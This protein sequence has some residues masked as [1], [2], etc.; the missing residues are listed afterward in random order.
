MN[1]KTRI[2]IV[3]PKRCKPKNCDQQC[4]RNCPVVKMGKLCI[5][6]K[7][8]D[9]IAE[10]SELLCNGCGICVKK[11][12]FN[13]IKIIN[14][15][16]NLDADTIHRYSANSF[17]LHRLPIPRRGQVLGLVGANGTGKSTAVKI[18]AK[19][20][21]LNLGDWN[22]P[23]EPEEV[24]A[25][26]RG[27]ELQNYFTKMYEGDLKTLIKPQ[28][29]DTIAKVV[30]GKVRDLILR[31]DERGMKDEIMDKLDLNHLYDREI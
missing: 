19:K 4:K 3:D 12:P 16:K 10:I 15:P 25:Y 29:V 31:K 1:N 22:Y 8:R 27:S 9:K 14:L 23:P 24:I 20:L 30:K 21:R 17:K 2:A 7:K 28:Y 13:A 6:V 18:L 5:Q 11:C 26:F